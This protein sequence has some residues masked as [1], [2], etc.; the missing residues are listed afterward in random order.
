MKCVRKRFCVYI[1]VLEFQKLPYIKKY[2]V[3]K[4]SKINIQ[5]G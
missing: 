1:T 5:K 3:Q 2:I 4:G